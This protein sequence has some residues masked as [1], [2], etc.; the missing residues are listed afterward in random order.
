MAKHRRTIKWGGVLTEDRKKIIAEIATK[1][2]SLVRE[3]DPIFIAADICS[4]VVLQTLDKHLKELEA[5]LDR[6]ETAIPYILDIERSKIAAETAKILAASDELQ[7]QQAELRAAIIASA[8]NEIRSRI[9]SYTNQVITAAREAVNEALGD[10]V[11]AAMQSIANGAAA[12]EQASS[13]LKRNA[14]NDLLL[15]VA[16]SAFGGLIAVAC[17]AILFF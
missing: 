3:D 15:V 6:G 17:S 1:Y 11:S 8:D 14:I 5:A 16:V 2:G 13:S 12:V 7:S 10:N 9:E 4:A